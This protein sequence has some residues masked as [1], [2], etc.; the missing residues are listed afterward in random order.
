MARPRY[1]MKCDVICPRDENGNL[2]GMKG[3]ERAGWTCVIVGSD[4]VWKCPS[5]QGVAITRHQTRKLTP[6]REEQA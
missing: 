1:C 3:M 4:A 5:C 2:L 6:W